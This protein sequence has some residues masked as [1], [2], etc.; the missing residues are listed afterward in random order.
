MR[1]AMAVV[2]SFVAIPVFAATDTWTGVVSNV[3]SVA[4]NWSGSVPA[5]GDDLVFPA[6]GMNQT[7]SND[8]TPGMAFNSITITG[9]KYTLNG[10][11]IALGAG[12]LTLTSATAFQT[13]NLPITLSAPQTWNLDSTGFFIF[14]DGSTNLN[15]MALTVK[16]ANNNIEQWPGV[17]AGDG[18]ITTTGGFGGPILQGANTTTAP[19]TAN[20]PVFVRGSYPGAITLNAAVIGLEIALGPG[21]TVGAVTINQGSLFLPLNPGGTATAASL[22][23]TAGFPLTSLVMTVAGTTPG[24]FSQLRVPNPGTVTLSN[25]QLSI[26]GGAV[27]TAVPVGSVLTIIDNQGS[28]P[29][30]GTFSGIPEGGSV[31]SAGTHQ[32]FIV[33]YVGGT[34]NDVTLTALGLARRRSVRH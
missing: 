17:I 23:V 34:G 27:D 12:G 1:Y 25:M 19:L 4:G 26:S 6:S 22:N 15:G 30:N 3:W 8:L 21:A 33:S 29:I 16:Y 10:N 11:G 18:S 9:G 7:T 28:G 24:T 2:F 20:G 13:M 31:L 5:A 14:I 32:L